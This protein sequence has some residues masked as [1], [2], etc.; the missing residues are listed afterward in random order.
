[1]VQRR[2]VFKS[3]DFIERCPDDH[4]RQVTSYAMPEVWSRRLLA[5]L[6]GRPE[7]LLLYEADH[8]SPAFRHSGGMNVGFAD[9]GCEWHPQAPPT[10]RELADGVLPRD[11]LMGPSR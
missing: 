4:A 9:G 10:A 5:P 11:G 8:S 2:Y 7:A 3:R 6:D 1:D